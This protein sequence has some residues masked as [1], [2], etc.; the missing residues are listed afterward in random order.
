MKRTALALTLIVALSLLAGTEL[1]LVE[2]AKANPIAFMPHSRVVSPE[3]MTYT[4]SSVSVVIIVEVSQRFY[5]NDSSFFYNGSPWINIHLDDVSLK[6]PAEVQTSNDSWLTF[7]G[8]TVVNDISD[9]PHKL[10][11]DY[12]SATIA[13]LNN[14]AVYF[15]VE[16][17]APTVTI[18]S[19]ANKTYENSSVP[20]IFATDKP[21][22]NASYS[23]DS[24]TKV[25]T[26]G[27]TTFTG[28]TA[29]AHNVTVYAWDT[30]GNVGASETVT[31]TVEKQPESTSEPEPFP[32]LP[33]AAVSVAVVA[34]A[35]VAALVYWKKHKRGANK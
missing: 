27:N 9:G 33:V 8:E 7:H 35:I 23:L 3:N 34:M 21:I 15:V 30:A 17:H 11:V 25:A 29:G 2:L 10:T 20:L 12:F 6:V 24:Q 13:S 16:T 19:P 18:L 31:F 32:W 5:Y 28:L 4:T 14:P 1:Q 26:D 22:S